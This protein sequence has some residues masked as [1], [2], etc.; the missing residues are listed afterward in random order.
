[1][2]RT[3]SSLYLHGYEE[4][5]QPN[6]SAGKPDDPQHWKNTFE[7]ARLDLE[8][9]LRVHD[10]YC[11]LARTTSL[12]NVE[13]GVNK[14]G[15][16]TIPLPALEVLQA[17][18]LRKATENSPVP[19]S[20]GSFTRTWKASDQLLDAFI[21]KQPVAKNDALSGLAHQS[22]IRTVHYRFNFDRA[23]ALTVVQEITSRFDQKTRGRHELEKRMFSLFALMDT[24]AQRLHEFYGRVLE[25]YEAT[26]R[27]AV[28]AGV[29]F[30]C[31]KSPLAS[32]AWQRVVPNARDDETLRFLAFQLSEISHEWIY[33]FSTDDLSD[34][35]RD[36]VS[37]LSA[38]QGAEVGEFEHI[39][40]NNPV[41]TKPFIEKPDGSFFTAVPHIPLAFPFRTI[42]ALLPNE[43]K[44]REALS[45]ARADV[46][47]ELVH[48][49]VQTAMPSA[50]VYK[51]V[52]WDDPKDGTRYEHDVVAVLGK[53]TRCSMLVFILAAGQV[54]NRASESISAHSMPNTS[55]VREPVRQVNIRALA[56][57]ALRPDSSA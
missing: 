54:H 3:N 16:Q 10:P 48:E 47:E 34:L 9:A 55:P 2:T 11:L 14:Q 12:C 43:G 15:P 20:W 18:L 17:M 1:M 13:G 21:R 53:G 39:F 44:T 8:T 40:M 24:T 22:R 52:I 35:D 29:E 32:R 41:W 7:K 42:E 23:A 30:L 49:T 50:K 33:T 56:A 28:I 31:E 4:P 5:E 38:K 25:I 19:V 36:T 27:S 6:E 46:L 45:D 57:I 37:K 26:E 51:S